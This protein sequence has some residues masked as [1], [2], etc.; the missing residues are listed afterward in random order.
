MSKILDIQGDIYSKNGTK[1][2]NNGYDEKDSFFNGD[3]ITTQIRL[4]GNISGNVILKSS[5]VSDN[6]IFE[7]PPTA[8]NTGDILS[9]QSSNGKLHWKSTKESSIDV[10]QSTGSSEIISSTGSY[11][12]TFD[13]SIVN[14]FSEKI[15]NST[16]SLNIIG[17]WLVETS[18]TCNLIETGS[19]NILSTSVD[20]SNNSNM[21]SVTKG[22]IRNISLIDSNKMNISLVDSLAV[23]TL[24]SFIGIETLTSGLTGSIDPNYFTKV[25]ILNETES[26][27]L[28]N[29]TTY[30]SAISYP[31]ANGDQYSSNPTGPNLII[32]NNIVTGM[33]N[34]DY[35]SH[36]SNLETLNY[37]ITKHKD[38][39]NNIVYILANTGETPAVGGYIYFWENWQFDGY[40]QCPHPNSDL[41]SETTGLYIAQSIKPRALIIAGTHR[42]NSLTLGICDGTTSVCSG[43]ATKHRLSDMSHQV[44]SYFFEGSKAMRDHNTS[45]ICVSIH[46][47]GS[48]TSDIQFSNGT[49]YDTA[50][51]IGIANIMRNESN[52]EG[53]TTVSANLSTDTVD[54]GLIGTDDTNGRLWNNQ[55]DP[56]QGGDVPVG[57]VTQKFLH[58]ECD[59]TFRQT[60]SEQDKFITAL[61]NTRKLI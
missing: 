43:G 29:I 54:A 45:S 17:N 21:T 36:S 11:I 34:G 56:C 44:L 22:N 14:K 30:E 57:D 51:T 23:S 60:T 55:F 50:S 26:S 39:D 52:N 1:I 42:C 61:L 9:Y 5:E 46:G 35:K 59:L 31:I 33:L 27:S 53:L 38:N 8:G 13:T 7:F 3:I 28:V 49:D 48:G 58:C 4:D 24:P 32:F 15:N 47:K 12:E 40:I 6:Y 2:L 19:N 41:D 10:Y 20:I 37:Q 18:F 25:T 16:I